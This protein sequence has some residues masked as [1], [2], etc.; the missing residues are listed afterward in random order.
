MQ[1]TQSSSRG[2]KT[3]WHDTARHF[4]NAAF[5]V[6]YIC[7]TNGMLLIG[8]CFTLLGESLLAPSALKHR[9]WSTL[10]VGGVFLTLALTTIARV[11]LS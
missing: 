8:S 1:L 9:S 3:T 2:Y 10:L 4:A 5:V 7:L 11:L 6:S